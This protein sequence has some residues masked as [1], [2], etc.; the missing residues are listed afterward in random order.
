M[1][2]ASPAA[3]IQTMPSVQLILKPLSLT[4]PDRLIMLQEN[5]AR[6]KIDIHD[7]LLSAAKVTTDNYSLEGHEQILQLQ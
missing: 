5:L 3:V 4:Q 1:S 7:L 6:T 2:P